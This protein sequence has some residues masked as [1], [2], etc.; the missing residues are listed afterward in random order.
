V[1]LSRQL[2][3]CPHLTSRREFERLASVESRHADRPG[4]RRPAPDLLSL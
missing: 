4:T 1:I 2:I 3:A